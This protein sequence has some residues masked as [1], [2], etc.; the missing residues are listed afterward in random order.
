[1]AAAMELPRKRSRA[2]S[3][4]VLAKSVE[5]RTDQQPSFSSLPPHFMDELA[6]RVAQEVTRHL[7]PLDVNNSPSTLLLPPAVHDDRAHAASELLEVPIRSATNV[8][9]P[10]TVSSGDL[11]AAIVQRPLE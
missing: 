8:P 7:S 2:P 1:M 9:V 10:N 4:P 5:Q 11:A 6:S 3:H